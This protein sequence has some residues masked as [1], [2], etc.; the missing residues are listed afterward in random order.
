[1][2]KTV[3]FDKIDKFLTKK[4]RLSNKISRYVY[5]SFKNAE[6][7]KSLR[8]NSACR[9]PMGMICLP[10]VSTIVLKERSTAP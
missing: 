4:S 9:N 10:G 2:K 6:I 3:G 1:M 7:M 5:K 8:K